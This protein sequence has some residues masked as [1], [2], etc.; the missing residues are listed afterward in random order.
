M[1]KS[2]LL[3]LG[4]L[5]CTL[6]MSAQTLP[7]FS[8]EGNETWYYIQFKNGGAVL[9]DMGDGINLVTRKSAKTDA[10]LW[11]LTGSQTSCE[12]I[13]K[14]GRHIY[15]NTTSSYYAASASKTGGLKLQATTNSTYAPAWEI[16][17]ASISGKSMNQWGGTGA[18]KSLGSWNAGDGNNPVEF[19]PQSEM[20]VTDAEPT[21]LSEFG[22]TAYNYTKLGTPVGQKALW[23]VRPVTLET[24]GNPWMEFAL[25]I[26]NGQFGGMIYGG[27]HQDR[28]QFNDKSLWTGSQT[29][30]GAYQNFG[31]L[32][33]NC[34]DE[35]DTKVRP[36]GYFRALD[37]A[38][39]TA[40]MCY[41]NNDSSVTY[42]REY[43]ASYPDQCIAIHLTASKAGQLN[44]AFYLYN[45][46]GAKAK[47]TSTG[48]GIFSGDL[49]TVSYR[50]HMKVIPTG[51]TMTVTDSAIVVRGA[52]EITVLLAGGTN[53]EPKQM[54][55]VYDKSQLADNI[56]QRITNA[57][58]KSWTAIY[59]AHEADYKALFDRCS[60]DL[61]G[62]DNSVP[63]YN[64][65]SYYNSTSKNKTGMEPNTLKL[66]ELYFTYG[67]YLMI[68]CSRGIDLPSNL[69]GIWNN[70]AAPPWES[71]IHSNINVQ[72]NYW[73]AEPTNLSELHTKY[74]NYVY[75]MAIVHPI[76]QQYA[77][78]SGQTVGWTCYTQNNI[79]GHSDY[80][81]NYVIANAWYASHL[82][83]HYRYTLDRDFLKSEGF[84]VMLSTTKYWLERLV[85]ANDGTYECPNEWSPEHGPSKENATA[86]A[87]QLVWDLF[88]STLKAIDVLGNTDAGVDDAFVT[89]LKNKLAKLD[90]GLAIET[91]KGTYGS[92]RNGVKTGDPILREW[93]YTDFATGNGSE[94]GHRH[95]SHLMCLYP[96]QQISQTSPYFIPAVNALKLRGDNSTGW[97]MGWRINLWARALDGNHAH[98]ILHNA[99]KH[100]TT[101]STD[102]SQGGIYYNL[103]D[104]HAPFQ[105]DG[106][107]GACAGVA[108][109][110]M[111]S[112]TDTIQVLPALP[113]VWKQGSVKGMKAVGNFTV[114]ETWAEGTATKV[115]VTSGSGGDCKMGYRGIAK[116][117]VT[118][119]EGAVTPT[120]V[121]DS[122]IVFPTKTGKSYTV[123]FTDGTGLQSLT[124]D[125]QTQPFAL[126]GRT[127]T[128]L[129][130]KVR[131]IAVNNLEGQRIMRSAKRSFSIP[132]GAGRL[133]ILTAEYGNGSDRSFKAVL[134]K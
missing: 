121:N 23:Y 86:H 32:Y 112:Y 35:Y 123:D 41:M 31:C 1:K 57:S 76:W 85:L 59:D 78:N 119:D 62:A 10:Q 5:L 49:L 134:N 98:T 26:G 48:D 106:N 63:T 60:L 19:V 96:L 16:Q 107:F 68:G 77:K 131:N 122:T 99:L 34:D 18:G 55:Y 71:D 21:V 28:V 75:N 129:D 51:G 7:T 110:L 80:M 36:R 65:V 84:P 83:Q 130:A 101:Y 50:A 2:F 133:V 95:Q 12:I 47:Y 79:F 15:Y 14:S 39:G 44:N 94:S 97:S 53:F 43:I 88:T 127:V 132:A 4:G 103:F 54:S 111:Q 58:A 6:C 8:S 3:T 93:K 114:D 42:K 116:A 125:S 126:H 25:P 100:S 108:E 38:T 37:M 91:Y 9:Q 118:S 30:R 56:D 74:L 90:T 24:V 92:P 89:D 13:G 61:T 128:V 45:P 52:D 67:R 117:K 105:I 69:Q 27:I 73:P 109:M 40:S 64:L 104:S 115:V 82:W 72:M 22:S 81:E 102:Q 20:A 113:S 29:V 124:G 11:K 120:V 17:T 70:S 33:I 87:Q 46:N 66:E